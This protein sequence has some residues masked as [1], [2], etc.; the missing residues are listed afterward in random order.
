MSGR[1]GWGIGAGMR[2]GLDLARIIKVTI[3][4]AIEWQKGMMRSAFE[5]GRLVLIEA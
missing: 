4:P 1:A 3:Q 5:P 2:A